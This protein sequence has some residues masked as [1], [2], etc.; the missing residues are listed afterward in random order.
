MNL[1][2]IDRKEVG[3]WND[4]GFNGSVRRLAVHANVK[5]GGRNAQ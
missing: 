1:V 4:L 5:K 2:V 3:E